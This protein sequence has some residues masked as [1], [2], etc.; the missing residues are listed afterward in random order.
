[1]EEVNKEKINAPLLMAET[2]SMFFVT[3][4]LYGWDMYVFFGVVIYQIALIVFLSI[5]GKR[6]EIPF[7]YLVGVVLW[8]LLELPII[9]RW[10]F[11]PTLYMLLLSVNR[12]LLGIIIENVKN[13]YIFI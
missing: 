13:D 1:M 10:I 12:I 5:M 8:Y 2:N 4:I 7:L 9:L 3:L 11:I 6:S